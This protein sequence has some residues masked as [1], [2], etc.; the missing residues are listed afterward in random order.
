ML[1]GRA[2]RLR[3]EIVQFVPTEEELAEIED[4]ARTAR[5]RMMVYDVAPPHVRN[6]VKERGE[7]VLQDWWHHQDYWTIGSDGQLARMESW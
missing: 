2:K 5:N 1:R 6:Q 7:K 4:N 3:D